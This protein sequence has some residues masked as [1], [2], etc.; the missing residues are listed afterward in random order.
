M[1]K[2]VASGRISSSSVLKTHKYQREGEKVQ[3]KR[4]EGYFRH[5]EA[6]RPVTLIRIRESLSTEIHVNRA[7]VSCLPSC[8]PSF[9]LPSVLVE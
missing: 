2:K 4:G 9:Y 5:R 8:L 3:W 1:D 7:A 6:W